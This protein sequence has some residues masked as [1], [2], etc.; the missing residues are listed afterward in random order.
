[1]TQMSSL[2]DGDPPGVVLHDVR[3]WRP[4]LRSTPPGK[5]LMGSYWVTR[6]NSSLIAQGYQQSPSEQANRYNQTS[7]G[8]IKE[9]EPGTVIG[10]VQEVDHHETMSKYGK[11]AVKVPCQASELGY[12]WVNVWKAKEKG[13]V[14]L[15][16]ANQ[17]MEDPGGGFWLLPNQG[18]RLYQGGLRF[19]GGE[20]WLP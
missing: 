17:Y 2:Q 20:V 3:T 6:I 16:I 7:K 11:V 8:W 9:Y 10:P 1:M 12:A 13:G 19:C 14:G 5:N 15:Y 4:A 18:G